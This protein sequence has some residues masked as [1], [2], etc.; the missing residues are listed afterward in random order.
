MKMISRVALA[1][2]L[3]LGAV[4]MTTAPAQAQDSKKDKKKDKGQESGD[5]AEAPLKVSDEYRKPAA[6]AEDAIKKQD[7]ATAATQLAAAD[8]LA[9]NDDELYFAALLRLQIE[10]H[11]KSNEG[12]IKAL[13]VLIPSPRTAPKTLAYYNF[14]RGNA[15]FLLKH[16]DEA[17]PYLLKARELGSPEQDLPIV[18]AQSYFGSGNV[19]QG[20]VEMG[21]AMQIERAAGRQVPVSWYDY[22]I[23]KVYASGDRTETARWLMQKYGDYPTTETWHTVIALYRDSKD[24]AKQT[25]DRKQKLDLY[26]LM[27]ATGTLADTGDYLEY[28][29]AAI[30]SG[31]PW[32]TIA[33]IDEGRAKG[34]L[35]KDES[36]SSKLYVS[37]QAMAK[38]DTPLDTYAKQAAASPKGTEALATGNGYLASGNPTRAVEMYDLALQKGSVD[39]SQ[40]NI[41]KGVALYKLNR[42]DEARAAFKLVQGVPLGDIAGFWLVWLDHPATS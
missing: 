19:A 27:R 32:E 14:L 41:N 34:K 9:K 8:A 26:R 39:P 29:Q 10:A 22:V 21:K 40:V 3:S 25:L 33:V 7:W 35:E 31:L 2:M 20:V 42:T 30:N 11:N 36:V 18:I 4:A 13:D 1:A 28:A 16:Y 12:M 24:K 6:A 15:A 5:P 23:A 37:A 38:S 17:L